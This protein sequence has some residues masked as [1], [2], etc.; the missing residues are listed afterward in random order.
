MSE[1]DLQKLQRLTAEVQSLKE[2]MDQEAEYKLKIIG[3]YF[4]E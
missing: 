4:L 3:K 2:K 1:T